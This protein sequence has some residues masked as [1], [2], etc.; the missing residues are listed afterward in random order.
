MSGL[1]FKINTGMFQ[2]D[3]V[4]YEPDIFKFKLGTVKLELDNGGLKPCN[5]RFK[6]K[7]KYCRVAT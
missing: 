1:N 4:K 2:L 7:D 3:N 5:V 6:L